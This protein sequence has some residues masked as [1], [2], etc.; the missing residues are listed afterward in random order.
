MRTLKCTLFFILVILLSFTLSCGSGGSGDSNEDTTEDIIHYVSYKDPINNIYLLH[1]D[2]W[3]VVYNGEIP[4]AFQSPQDGPND[5]FAEGVIIDY[6]DPE[7]TPDDGESDLSDVNILETFDTSLS[8][9]YARKIVFEA[10]LT[11][12][13][14]DIRGFQIS[15][16]VNDKI[17][18]VT[19]FAESSNY[20]KY[21]AIANKMVESMQIGVTIA[22]G[23]DNADSNTEEPGPPA[24][25]FDGERY[26]VVTYKY[27]AS[28]DYDTPVEL[29]GFFV[30]E[31]FNISSPVTI[32]QFE[33]DWFGLS[34]P[35]VQYDGT[36]YMVVFSDTTEEYFGATIHIYGVRI[37]PSGE[38]LDKDQPI[39]ISDEGQTGYSPTIESNGENFLVAWIGPG[40]AGGLSSNN[41]G[42]VNAAL[43]SHDGTIIKRFPIFTETG[44]NTSR[45]LLATNGDGFI[46]V[47]QKYG[48]KEP[49]DAEIDLV[50]SSISRDGFVM[51]PE[52]VP[53]ASGPGMQLAASISF[54]GSNYLISWLDRQPDDSPFYPKPSSIYGRLISAYGPLVV[55]EPDIPD[56]IIDDTSSPK[57]YLAQGFDG[58]NHFLVWKTDPYDIYPDSG[59]F[60]AWISNSGEKLDIFDE[61][62]G[63]NFTGP[64]GN[65]QLVHPKVCFGD[66]KGLIIWIDI[67]GIYGGSKSLH[68]ILMESPVQ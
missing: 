12:N 48:N 27:P 31:D 49:N 10:V 6:F 57:M 37:T 44:L 21:L 42:V 54:D 51:N 9:L 68:G 53:I 38:V 46:A 63:P 66:S 35:S 1:P 23:L 61:V 25:A 3:S 14:T 30:D 18:V 22:D 60:S 17:C 65:S 29:V 34:E 7:N 13:N 2:T 67:S 47:W 36:N 33:L 19:Y 64:A 15:S 45:P 11:D 41:D 43:L 52:G 4:V 24:I 8:G 58:T 62:L 32:H 55:N 39:M 26:L 28:G 40:E 50:G 5:T 16:L 56:I 20:E 59:L